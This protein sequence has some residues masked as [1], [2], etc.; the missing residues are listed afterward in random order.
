MARPSRGDGKVC[1][2]GG[3]GGGLEGPPVGP[4]CRHGRLQSAAHVSRLV[5]CFP[6]TN[7]NPL[8]THPREVS[9]DFGATNAA[10]GVLQAVF[11][12]LL[13]HYSRLLE[14]LKRQGPAGVALTREAVSLPNVMYGLNALSR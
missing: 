12:Q 6:P 5:S 3:G 11:T 10:K 14:L 8:W 1:A 9:R 13:M 2:W 7:P 4:D